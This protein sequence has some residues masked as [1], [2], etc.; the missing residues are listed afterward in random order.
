[1][2]RQVVPA[3]H[4]RSDPTPWPSEPEAPVVHAEEPRVDPD[5]LGGGRGGRHQRGRDERGDEHGEQLGR[6]TA[7]ERARLMCWASSRG[8]AEG[9]ARRKGPADRRVRR[10]RASR[11]QCAGRGITQVANY[12]ECPQIRCR[13]AGPMAVRPALRR[14]RRPGAPPCAAPPPARVVRRA[15]QRQPDHRGDGHG[16]SGRRRGPPS[17]RPSRN[18]AAVT[19]LKPAP[20]SPLTLPRRPT[21]LIRL[22]VV[23]SGT[24]KPCESPARNHS[25]RRPPTAERGSSASTARTPTPPAA[26]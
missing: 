23:I 16:H 15:D 26:R 25:G 19:V 17:P 4:S 8:G 5:L 1:M 6:G 2:S 7:G 10:S 14:R 22:T 12:G 18:V 24:M 21:G 3:S 11:D 9:T 13:S 20:A